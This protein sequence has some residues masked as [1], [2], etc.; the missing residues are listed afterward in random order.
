MLKV[1]VIFFFKSVQ[2][3]YVR[4]PAPSTFSCFCDVISEEVP[5]P[6]QGGYLMI[7]TL[8]VISVIF[9]SLVGLVLR[10][11][12]RIRVEKKISRDQFEGL[13]QRFRHG[14]SKDQIGCLTEDG[15][16][17]Y[18]SAGHL[19]AIQQPYQHKWEI[20]R[21]DITVGERKGF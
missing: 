13:I 21:D 20:N 3:N 14:F 8:S 2:L 9:V 4:K 16:N 19:T 17:P 11:C 18:V 6:P 10:I 12:I 5:E 7:I 1:K 15:N